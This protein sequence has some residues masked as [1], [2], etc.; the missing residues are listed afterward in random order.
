ME[1]EEI[2]KPE[3][4]VEPEEISKPEEV[5]EP[6]ETVMTGGELEKTI[7]AKIKENSDNRSRQKMSV[8]PPG[9]LSRGNAGRING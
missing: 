3:E 9:K 1:P 4:V 7:D 8:A 6:E 2:S 5:V